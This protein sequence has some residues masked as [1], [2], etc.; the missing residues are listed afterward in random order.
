MPRKKKTKICTETIYAYPKIIKD[1]ATAK[2]V[3]TGKPAT[4]IKFADGRLSHKCAM[5]K[6]VNGGIFHSDN[7]REVAAINCEFQNMFPE[8]CK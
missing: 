8:R 4:C 3:I 5:F 2:C 7:N 6:G 1:Y